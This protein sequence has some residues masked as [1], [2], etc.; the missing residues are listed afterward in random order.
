[1]SLY[2]FAAV[3]GVVALIG[4]AIAGAT[5]AYLVL[6]AFDWLGRGDW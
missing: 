5:V 6:T 1:M 2:A 4:A 3:V